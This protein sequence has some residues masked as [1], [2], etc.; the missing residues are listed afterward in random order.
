MIVSNS[1]ESAA[2]DSLNNTNIEYL[3]SNDIISNGSIV[4]TRSLGESSN[5]SIIGRVCNVDKSKQ[6]VY[7]DN[8][9]ATTDGI[10]WNYVVEYNDKA[11]SIGDPFKLILRLIDTEEF[12]LYHSFYPL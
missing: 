6:R 4:R 2:E 11:L 8:A 3:I 10:E 12:D 5:S 1:F 7:Y 9:I